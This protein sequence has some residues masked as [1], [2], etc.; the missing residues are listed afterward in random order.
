MDANNETENSLFFPGCGFFTETYNVG[1]SPVTTNPM[2]AGLPLTCPPYNEGECSGSPER[3]YEPR[4][5]L[6]NYEYGHQFSNQEYYND[7]HS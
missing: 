6:Y 1:S 5:R 3:V 7:P 4:R 2:A